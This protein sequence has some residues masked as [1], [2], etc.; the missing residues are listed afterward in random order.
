MVHFTMHRENWQDLHPLAALLKKIPS[1]KGMTVQLFYPYDQ[2]ESSLALTP[3]T[4]PR[5]G[6]RHFPEENL[7]GAQ[8]RKGFKGYD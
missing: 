6:K 4:T 3:G 5:S 8:L 2:G 1:V 7:S